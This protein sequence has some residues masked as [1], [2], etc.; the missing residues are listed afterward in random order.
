MVTKNLA[1]DITEIA[2]VSQETLTL[3]QGKTA[4]RVKAPLRISS[5]A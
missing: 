1:R 2:T 4:L 3:P 5:E